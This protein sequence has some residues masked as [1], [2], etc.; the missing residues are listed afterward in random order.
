[1]APDSTLNTVFILSKYVWQGNA[2]YTIDVFDMS[3]YLP[4]AQ[5]P[6]STVQNGLGRLGRFIRWGSNGL[7]LNDTQGN[8]YLISGSFVG[9]T[10][11]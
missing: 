10:P 3:H 8:V 2:N 4:V 7:A 5:I 1:M 6:F 11:R 9:V